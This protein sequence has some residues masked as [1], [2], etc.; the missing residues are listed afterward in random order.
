[1]QFNF[2]TFNKL[3]PLLTFLFF[4]VLNRNLI[5]NRFIILTPTILG[6]LLWFIGEF[7]YTNDDSWLIKLGFSIF[8]FGVILA[9]VISFKKA[10][11]DK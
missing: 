11:Q 10:L 1:M 6:T 2:D 7:T 3:I 5:K 9:S 4:I 8:M